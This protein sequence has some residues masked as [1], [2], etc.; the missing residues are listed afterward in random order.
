MIIVIYMKFIY[1]DTSGRDGEN[2][3]MLMHK[4]SMDGGKLDI[5]RKI[6]TINV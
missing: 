2:D 4:D 1:V 6:C 3:I 5:K